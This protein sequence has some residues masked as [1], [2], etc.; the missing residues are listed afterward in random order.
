MTGRRA[1]GRQGTGLDEGGNHLERERADELDHHEEDVVGRLEAEAAGCQPA[2][3]AVL[4][5][6]PARQEEKKV[7]Q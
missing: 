4:R 5:G 7:Q 6:R 1:G 3:P 2:V